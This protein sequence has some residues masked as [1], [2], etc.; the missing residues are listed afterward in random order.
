M[1]LRVL[2]VDDNEGFLSAARDL[3]ESEGAT[4]V[5][6]AS[7]SAD[8]LRHAEELRPDVALV[9][10]DLDHESGFDVAQRIACLSGKASP[11]ILIS[12]YPEQDFIDLIGGSPALGFLSKS[13]LTMAAV[14]ALL[15]S[16]NTQPGGG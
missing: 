4:V 15:R 10:I 14:S 8:A 3:L 9:D 13:S 11:V 12:A 2:I 16:G 7:S 5:A 1:T 6:T